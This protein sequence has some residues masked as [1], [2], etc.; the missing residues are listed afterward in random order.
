M[1]PR[2][3]SFRIFSSLHDHDRTRSCPPRKNENEPG[4]GASR[5]SIPRTNPMQTLWN[6]MKQTLPFPSPKSVTPGWFGSA[7]HTTY[8]S[9][10]HETMPEDEQVRTSTSTLQQDS[11]ESRSEIAI[12]FDDG[13]ASFPSSPDEDDDCEKTP[14]LSRAAPYSS[15]SPTSPHTIEQSLLYGSASTLHHPGS[16]S[17]ASSF[18]PT[19]PHTIL[20]S[21]SDSCLHISKYA[22]SLLVTPLDSRTSNSLALLE[23]TIT[24]TRSRRTSTRRPRASTRDTSHS[25]NTYPR[26]AIPEPL[27]RDRPRSLLIATNFGTLVVPAM[28]PTPQLPVRS[29]IGSGGVVAQR[30]EEAVKAAAFG[31]I[32]T[33]LTGR[34]LSQDIDAFFREL[35]EMVVCAGEGPGSDSTKLDGEVTRLGDDISGSEKSNMFCSEDDVILDLEGVERRE[36]LEV[37]PWEAT[38]EDELVVKSAPTCFWFA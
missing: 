32:Q 2:S 34:P 22:S 29:S 4:V 15:A 1:H 27:Q 33:L 28:E 13:V 16:T 38:L 23:A 26:P 7:K 36:R 30:G 37:C 21:R 20:I 18:S 3:A 9:T 25:C 17:E 24:P 8:A 12:C 35:E 14:T 31:P 11:S 19:T 6:T 10:E 5:N